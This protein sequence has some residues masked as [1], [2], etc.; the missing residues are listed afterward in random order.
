MKMS[1]TTLHSPASTSVSGTESATHE[2]KV[3]YISPVTGMQL[4]DQGAID[5]CNR[6]NVYLKLALYELARR[7]SDSDT[8]NPPA[9]DLAKALV[10]SRTQTESPSKKRKVNPSTEA[11]A[12]ST[13]TSDN[14]QVASAQSPKPRTRKNIQTVVRV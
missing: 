7:N 3:S 5:C 14:V 4:Q 10:T 1:E 9:S 12:E 2:E 8:V 6:S 13:A 11:V